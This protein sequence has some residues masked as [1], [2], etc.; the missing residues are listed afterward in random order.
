MIKQYHMRGR[1]VVMNNIN[2]SENTFTALIMFGERAQKV[3]L[4]DTTLSLTEQK[5]LGN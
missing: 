3:P 4:C 5:S 2:E 1:L